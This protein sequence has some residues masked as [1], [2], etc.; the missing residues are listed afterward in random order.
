MKEEKEIHHVIAFSVSDVDE[1]PIGPQR[2]IRTFTIR[3]LLGDE[4][5]VRLRSENRLGLTLE[6][7]REDTVVPK[8]RLRRRKDDVGRGRS[9]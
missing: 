1:L 2:Y 9:D 7:E 5:V 8:Q 3:T 6:H 4:L